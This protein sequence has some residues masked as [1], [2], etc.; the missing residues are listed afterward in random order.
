M[1]RPYRSH[2]GPILSILLGLSISAGCGSKKPAETP[3]SEPQSQQ[4]YPQQAPAD[5]YSA[6]EEA[7]GAP[8]VG[9]P[10]P[11][12][13]QMERAE[14]RAGPSI[15][16]LSR[17]L[18]SALTLSTPDCPTAHLLRDRICELSRRI[19]GLSDERR[20]DHELVERCGDARAR[21]QRAVDRTQSAC[22]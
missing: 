7:E 12:S 1:N 3:A 13:M 11:G 21:C 22:P 4:G 6:D 5:S 17:D 19:C 10:M 18:E 9:A 15:E 14:D 2:A 8:P 16:M 20:D